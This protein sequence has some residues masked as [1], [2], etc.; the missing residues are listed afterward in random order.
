MGDADA[1]VVSCVSVVW[2]CPC[3]LVVVDDVL[4]EDEDV[5][6]QDGEDVEVM[7]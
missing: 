2:D 6:P 1:A 5:C 3:C 4:M 7:S